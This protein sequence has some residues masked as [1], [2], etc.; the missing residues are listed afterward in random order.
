MSGQEQGGEVYVALPAIAAGVAAAGL[1]T[2][3]G[4]RTAESTVE[5][6]VLP[7]PR[8]ATVAANVAIP[9]PNAQ[10]D[11]A[12]PGSTAWGRDPSG[13]GVLVTYWS[14][15]SGP[16]TVLVRTATGS[17]RSQQDMLGADDLRLF[18]FPDVDS[19]AVREVLLMT[20]TKRCFVRADSAT[21]G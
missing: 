9:P 7:V 18:E 15:G 12:C 17:D 2:A 21:F 16:V 10:G 1:L 19:G 6:T 3:C 5:P 14:D 13:V 11:P 4:E 20:S 8:T